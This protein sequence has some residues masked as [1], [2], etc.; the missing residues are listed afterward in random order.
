VSSVA[1]ALRKREGKRVR[2]PLARLSVVV[3]DA[4]ALAQFDAHGLAPFLSRYARLDALAGREVVLHAD[5]D[6]RVG[7][8]VGLSADGALRVR[9]AG[10]EHNVHAGEVS[11][12]AA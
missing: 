7:Q 8:V 12:R 3:T 4:A 1:N 9:I 6:D 5:G 10:C 2:L 11:V